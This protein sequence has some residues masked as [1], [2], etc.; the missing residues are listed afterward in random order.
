VEVLVDRC[1]GL[2]VHKKSVTACVR[3]PG[4]KGQ[5]RQVVRTYKTFTGELAKLRAWLAEEGVTR[6]AMESTGV[7]WKPLWHALEGGFELLL[8]NARH[9]KALPGRKTDVQDAAWLAQ[10]LECGLLRGSFVPPPLIR[11]LR[12]LTR[13]RKRLI[14]DQVREGQRVEKLLEDAGIKLASVASK[15]LGMSGR[16][17]LAALC[18]GER[19]PE[20]LAELALG[21]LRA[22]L[23]E[24]RQALQGRFGEHHQVMLDAV[25]GHVDHLEAAIAELDRRIDLVIAPFAA[26]RDRLCTIPGIGKRTAE[27]LIAEIGVDMTQFPTAAHLASWAKICPGNNESAGKHRSGKNPGGNKWLCAALTQAAWAAARTKDTYLASHFWHLAR[28]VGK[29]KAAVAVGHTI[30]VSAYHMLARGE[31]YHELGADYYTRRADPQAHQRR[32]VHQL[33]KL[34]LKVTVEPADAT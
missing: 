4:E 15:T 33:E 14:E 17:M 20:V 12:D 31:D 24:L 19:D 32:L 8:V 23:A 30:L 7:L 16:A 3:T 25:L 28:T 29:N 26:L 13:Y 18:D 2:D 21:R 5:R 11:Q 9:V 27:V 1:A 34:G 22:R 10:L 6:V